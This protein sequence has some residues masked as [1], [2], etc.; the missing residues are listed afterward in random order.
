MFIGLS[1][2]EHR[3][4]PLPEGPG[5]DYLGPRLRVLG[6]APGVRPNPE[7]EVLGWEPPP[8]LARLYGVHGGLGPWWPRPSGPIDRWT[9]HAVLPWDRVTPLTRH[10]RFGEEDICFDPADS[11][12][13]A[14]D[15][16]GGGLVLVG[17]DQP[18]ICWFDGQRHTLS[19]PWSL[20]AALGWVV[21]GWI[22]PMR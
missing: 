5:V 4:V 19:Q 8:W 18:Q 22:L 13:I 17:R 9:H 11:V 16:S 6:G 12:R 15:G 10:I 21:S 1:E 7:L 20:D 3:A 14:A 2:V